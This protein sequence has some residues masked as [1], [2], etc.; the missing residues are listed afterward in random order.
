MDLRFNAVSYLTDNPYGHINVTGHICPVHGMMAYRGAEIQ[1]H[2]C[3]TQLY[4]RNKSQGHPLHTKW[5][6]PRTFWRLDLMQWRGIEP[7]YVNFEA[8]T[9]RPPG[10]TRCRR[11]ECCCTWNR[12][13]LLYLLSYPHSINGLIPRNSVQLCPREHTDS[14]LVAILENTTRCSSPFSFL[15]GGGVEPRIIL[16]TQHRD[17]VINI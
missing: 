16:K 6:E 13:H 4:S 5:G 3:F 2:S 7:R 12:S 10:S 14:H 8:R 17:L 15:T 9:L 1:L 11:N